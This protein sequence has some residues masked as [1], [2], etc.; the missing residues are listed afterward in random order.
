MSTN[1]ESVPV[2]PVEPP[3]AEQPNPSVDDLQADLEATRER[4]AASV[5][6][7]AA[8]ADV[9]AQAKA[10]ASETADQVK[11]K[12]S[13]TADQVKAGAE[14]ALAQVRQ[15]PPAVLGA[16]AVGVVV[17]A[18]LLIRRAKRSG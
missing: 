12:A 18:V 11:A 3:V 9:K 2:Q 5:E 16:I 6:A 8:K 7:L 1:P 14:D 15:V 17:V 10:K 4:L 13:E